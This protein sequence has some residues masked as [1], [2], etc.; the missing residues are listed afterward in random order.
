MTTL[1]TA[2]TYFFSQRIQV[3]SKSV[4]KVSERHEM[5]SRMKERERERERERGKKMERRK[6]KE[7]SGQNTIFNL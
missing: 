2:S 6:P 1:K 4:R 3:H 5:Y 7:K